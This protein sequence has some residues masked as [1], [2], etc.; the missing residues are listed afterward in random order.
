MDNRIKLSNELKRRGVVLNSNTKIHT[1]SA[2]NEFYITDDIHNTSGL[3]VQKVM[4]NSIDE[5]K[6]Y[7]SCSS[8][9]KMG[10]EQCCNNSVTE[11]NPLR[12]W[13]YLYGNVT[14]DEINQEDLYKSAFP[15]E[16][17][18]GD[19]EELVVEKDHPLILPKTKENGPMILTFRR[20]IL[21]EGAKVEIHRGMD[22]IVSELEAESDQNEIYYKKN[23]DQAFL[24]Y[25][26]LNIACETVKGRVHVSYEHTEPMNAYIFIGQQKGPGSFFVN[27]RYSGN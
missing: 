5:L 25:D 17:L 10:N 7:M 14:K 15:M 9:S 3:S 6:K 2:K 1:A 4:I 11:D 19:V 22:I 8:S 16:L 13:N 12:I 20:L 21:R 24:A 23:E 27:P 26:T 18:V